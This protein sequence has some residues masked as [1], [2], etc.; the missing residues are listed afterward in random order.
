MSLH[1]HLPRNVHVLHVSP[2]HGVPHSMSIVLVFRVQL[3]QMPAKRFLRRMAYYHCPSML[4]LSL[5]R[6]SNPRM[7]HPFQNRAALTPA[8]ASK[9]SSLPATSA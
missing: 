7:F 8:Y 4:A 9:L 3:A 6:P 5:I 2:T 1:H